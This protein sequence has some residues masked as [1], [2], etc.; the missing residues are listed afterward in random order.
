MQFKKLLLAASAMATAGAFATSS[1]AQQTAQIGL[2]EIVVT[3][4]KVEENLMQVPMAITA[5]SSKDID[6]MG[7]KQLIDISAMT[8]SFNMVNQTGGSGRNDRSASSL[9]FRGLYVNLNAGATAGGLLF[10]NGT[11]VIGAQPP[12]I[13]EVERIEVL[14]GPQSAYFGRSTFMGA[15]NFVTREPNM[16]EY[17]GRF[18][19][20]YGS[21]G[22]SEENVSFE[23]PIV[24]D[25]LAAR[26]S[27]RYYYRG[28]QYVNW[29]NTNERMGM[30]STKSIA[31]SFVAQPNDNL[32]LKAYFNYFNDSDGQSA[33]GAIKSD[34]FN[35][36][37]GGV[38]P[39]TRVGNGYYCGELPDVNR[40][41]VK[42]ISADTTVYPLLKDVLFTRPRYPLLFDPTFNQHFGLERKAVQADFH[43]DYEFA[44]GYTFN[45]ITA[46]HRDKTSVG[47]DLNYRAGLDRPNPIYAADPVNRLSW[48]NFT[49]WS[50]G[51]SRDWSQEIRF[52]SPPTERF[53]W[54][55]G[56][57]YLNYASPGGVVYGLANTGPNFSTSITRGRVYTPAVFGGLYF[58]IVDN[59]TLTGEARYQWDHVRNVPLIAA[60]GTPV[61][62]PL[63]AI[64]K[65]TFKSFAPRV[66]LDY[67]FAPNSTA[68][69]LWSRGYRPGG[70]NIALLTNPARV[71]AAIQAAAPG[72][73]GSYLQEQLDN[74]EAG[75]KA[76]FFD[77]RARTTI[78]VY[79]DKWK[80][81][82]SGASIPV[83]LPATPTDPAITNLFN[84]T[85]N[86]GIATLNGF[87]FEGEFQVSEQLKLSGNFALNTSKI[88]TANL[89][90]Y[91]CTDCANILGNNKLG[92]GNQLPTAPKYTWALSAEYTDH[93]TGD[94]DWY[95]RVDYSHRG[96]NFT[97]F[98]NVAWVGASDKINMRIGARNDVFSIEGFVTNL[99]ND[100]TLLAGLTGVDVFTFIPGT[101]NRN[102]IRMSLPL[103]R[104]WGMRASYNF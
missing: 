16:T 3:A 10:V 98:S 69:A 30:Q 75:F 76:T 27:G 89:A 11:P 102:E 91:S 50:Q 54:M 64:Q 84:V 79:H 41:P 5:F 31:A 94:Y 90:L 9:T 101:V 68:Y 17:K 25:K 86:T 34:Q 51:Y 1:H 45:S 88:G 46:Y 103:P 20:E 49:Q 92:L 93:L 61:L 82:Q 28:G 67:K 35:C 81:G 12:A 32:K 44:D 43:I 55:A 80:N 58:D 85:V 74:F 19:A 7:I 66:S 37:P 39:A 26:I 52:T 96:R 57:S 72:A 56:G 87:E 23:G 60:T 99:N 18:S 104:M 15:I 70:F 95:A 83:N 21:F 29:A 24:A 48:L 65:N 53:R 22:S 14:K 4:R 78:A 40:I 62:P 77:N 47:I 8:P 36:N 2:E 97:D 42:N 63:N 100:K 13:S 71:V 38:N 59:L 73:T 6:S 33:Q